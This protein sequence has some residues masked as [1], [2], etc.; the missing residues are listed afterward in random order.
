VVKFLR[1][2]P[3]ADESVLT[4]ID[5]DLFEILGGREGNAPAEG[6][7]VE[8]LLRKFDILQGREKRFQMMRSIAR[9]PQPWVPRVFVGLLA[10]ASDEVRD[11]A[12]RE[13]SERED[14]P[15]EILH[16][17][18]RRPP[19]YVKSAIL[20][21]LGTKG[22]P[23]SVRHIR[24]IIEDPNVDV[25]RAA[26]QALGAIGGPDSRTLLVRLTRDVNPYVRAAATEALDKIVELKFS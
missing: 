12:V 19:W 13:L 26:A 9:L 7:I 10:E 8:S 14:C 5:P 18:L 11:F 16:D 20:R 15:L 6:A 17:L 24:E 2:R 25:K 21:I 4:R 23:E 22:K 1:R 3:L